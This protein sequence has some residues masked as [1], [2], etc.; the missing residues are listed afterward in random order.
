L[1]SPVFTVAAISTAVRYLP[2]LVP[3]HARLKYGGKSRA[4]TLSEYNP[5]NPLLREEQRC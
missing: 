1:V 4:D 3:D 2:S 5:T